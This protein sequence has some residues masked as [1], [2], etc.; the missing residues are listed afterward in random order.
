M[1]PGKRLSPRSCEAYS[2]RVAFVVAG[3]HRQ[4]RPAGSRSA[5]KDHLDVAATRGPLDAPRGQGHGR[6]CWPHVHEHLCVAGPHRL[7]DRPRMSHRVGRV[8]RDRIDHK[9]AL[10]CLGVGDRPAPSAVV[11]LGRVQRACE[12]GGA[13]RARRVGRRTSP[14]EHCHEEQQAR[15][16]RDDGGREQPKGHDPAQNLHRND[17]PGEAGP[18]DT[19]SS[20]AKPR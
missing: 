13:W 8:Q 19:A 18:K 9:G 12:G 15:S 11:W 20:E 2:G 5:S 16:P 3:R 10:R 1:A 14:T 4:V 7:H 6:S 17:P